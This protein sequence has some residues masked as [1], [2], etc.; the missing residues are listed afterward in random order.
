MRVERFT[1]IVWIL[2][3]AVLIL[4]ALIVSITFSI[5]SGVI[6]TFGMGVLYLFYGLCR[7]RIRAGRRKGLL[8]WMRIP[9]L[10][11]SALML[12]LFAFIA[13][14][15]RMD[16]VS[17]QE[18]AVIV[19]GTALNGEEV[20]PPL[21]SRLDVAVEYSTANPHAVIAVAGGQGPG[22]SITEALAMERYLVSRGVAEDRIMRED[23]S[24]S[25]YE[26]FVFA[27]RLLHAHFDADYTTAF[28]TNDYHV[29]R[30]GEIAEEAGIAST[31]AH[32]DTP[33]YEIPVDYVRESLAITKFVLTGR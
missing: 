5:N 17:Y 7:D 1:K 3:G 31:H 23:R 12:L 33:W 4:D 11:G 24:T 19:L 29:Y 16:T 8:Q 20:T 2:L 28:I 26:N 14:L 6:A 25:T 32:A 21:R 27:K 13:V 18:D 22:E 15:G 10:I 30:A 9:I